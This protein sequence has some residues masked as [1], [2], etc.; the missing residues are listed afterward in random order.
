M[1][2]RILTSSLF[3][4]VVLTLMTTPVLGDPEN[5]CPFLINNPNTSDL[6]ISENLNSSILLKEKCEYLEKK[7]LEIH[8]DRAEQ[9]DPVSQTLIAQVYLD[10]KFLKQDYEKAYTYFKLAASQGNEQAQV[11]LGNLYE[12]GIGTKHS[13]EEALK[14][15]QKAARQGNVEALFKLGYFL[16]FGLGTEKN[17][18]EA[19][20]KYQKSLDGTR[21]QNVGINPALTRLGRIYYFGLGVKKDADKAMKFFT[22]AAGTGD[23][24]GQFMLGLFFYNEKNFKEAYQ[25]FLDSAKQGSDEAYYSIALMFTRGQVPNKSTDLDSAVE[26]AEKSAKSKNRG[27]MRLLADIYSGTFDQRKKDDEKAFKW[28]KLAAEQGDNTSVFEMAKRLDIG[29]GVEINKEEALKH[30]LKQ[31]DFHSDSANNVGCFYEFGFATAVNYNKAI[32]YYSKAISLAENPRAYN[33]LARIFRDGPDEHRDPSKSIDLNKQA[34]EIQKDFSR[35]LFDLGKQYEEGRGV[36]RDLDLAFQYY[37]KA[38]N[39]NFAPAHLELS[40]F[41]EFGKGGTPKNEKK[42]EEWNEKGLALKDISVFSIYDPCFKEK[43]D[44]SINE[45][46]KASLEKNRAEPDE[47]TDIDKYGRYHALVIGNNNYEKLD[48]LKNAENDARQVGFIL[49]EHFNFNSKL[50]L[51]AKRR[52]IIK[53]IHQYRKNLGPE[54]NLLI[55]YAGH[56]YLDE[57][58][59][60]GYWQ[61]VDA[62]KDI[63]DTTNW[64]ANSEIVDPLKAIGA[65]HILIVADSCFAGSLTRGLDLS[66]M[67]DTTD[68]EWIE[69]MRQHRGRTVLASGNLE[70]VSDS[71]KDGHSIFAYYF[72][73]ELRKIDSPT[74]GKQLFNKIEHKVKLNADQSPIYA[75]LVH[76]GSDIGDFIFVKNE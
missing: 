64:I 24:F 38:A 30:Y 31:A 50:I 35:S 3:F 66:L 26:N 53:S 54:D 10:G 62:E 14:W 22:Q 61:P 73:Q 55:Y 16:E 20:R 19:R 7:P 48:D 75:R 43:N 2:I 25:L 5:D 4:V 37:E 18:V 42:A 71:G 59:N 67:H 56:G 46:R 28:Y 13:Y 65:K 9:G 51:N 8:R 15:Y 57:E 74:T 23:S 33:N 12:G 69:K 44:F 17:I 11:R 6:R 60:K 41:Y 1:G 39:N 68:E 45:E 34:L 76:A 52:D 58:I 40:E 72:L 32:E 36:R 27:A 21:K 70:P 49:K 63:Y 29:V 47:V